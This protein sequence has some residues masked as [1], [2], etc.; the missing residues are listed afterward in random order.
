MRYDASGRPDP[1]GQYM[2]SDGKLVR[3]ALQEGEYLGFNMA[4]CDAASS[5]ART[6]SVF[7]RDST[8][9]FTD[10]ERTFADSV[11]GQ[12]SVSKARGEHLLR[13]RYMGDNAPA[14]TDAHATAAVK[15]ALT[16]RAATKQ[17][18]DQMSAQLPELQRQADEARQ[19]HAVGLNN[20]RAGR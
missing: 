2:M 15:A 18:V 12:A 6:A 17:Y 4:F 5:R 1:N 7:L 13:T 3:S 11:E 9:T 8:T 10:A 20:W 16:Q 14:F 19:R